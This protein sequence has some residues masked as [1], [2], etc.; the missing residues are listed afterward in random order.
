[1]HLP[2]AS[3]PVQHP[4]RFTSTSHSSFIDLFCFVFQRYIVERGDAENHDILTYFFRPHQ[5]FFRAVLYLD[6]EMF[7]LQKQLPKAGRHL[8]S[9]SLKE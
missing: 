4:D 1:M 7:H 6:P 3:R 5:N 9:H 2:A 8:L